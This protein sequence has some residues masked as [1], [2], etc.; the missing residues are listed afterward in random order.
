MDLRSV[1]YSKGYLP[2]FHLEQF[3]GQELYSRPAAESGY[4]QALMEGLRASQTV[5]N[6]F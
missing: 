2:K 3:E 4:F 1:L 5:S 6:N